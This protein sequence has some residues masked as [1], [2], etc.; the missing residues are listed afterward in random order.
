MSLEGNKFVLQDGT[1][2]PAIGFG[3]GTKWFKYGDNSLNTKLVE[4][5]EAA[6]ASGFVHLDGA[7]VYNT[8]RETGEGIRK[9][10]AD[11]SSLFITDK[12]F[13]GDLSYKAHSIEA[14]P[15]AALEASLT[16]YGIEY[17]DLY[18]LHA[19]F[20]K[21]AT[22]GFDLVEAWRYLEKA[23]DEGKARI[24]GI[25]NFTVED[26]ETILKLNPK[27]KP[28]VH[29]IE[30]NAYLQNQTPGI[31][32]FDKKHG[33]LT[34][35][36]SP[37]APIYKGDSNDSL[38][39]YV[40]EIASKYNKTSGQ[41]LLRWVLQNG[42]LPITTSSKADRLKQYLDIF[43]FTLSEDEVAN[44]SQLGSTKKVRQYWLTEYGKL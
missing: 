27:Y 38:L 36:Y 7:E 5:V 20:I 39:K 12:Y 3:T 22:H 28:Q 2:I 31:V 42:I 14:N 4:G 24:I 29:Q 23:K 16:R 9:F 32:E 41:I 18:L 26:I 11:R 44:I 33:I 30:Y 43:D 19:P 21:K 34:E 8:D 40:E 17:V 13:A 35:A 6:L 25:S 1:S 10:G 37:L 15:Y